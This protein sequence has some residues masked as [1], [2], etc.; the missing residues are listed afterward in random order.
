MNF[1][2]VEIF[3][4]IMECASITEAAVR[5]SLS[6]PAV[7]KS[8]KALEDE[9]A[10]RLFV[11][12]TKGLRATDEA[13]ELYAEASR[14]VMGFT[15]L[16]AFAQ[17]LRQLRHARI[18]V[19]AMTALCL[20]W[21]P[22]A[23]AGFVRLYPEVSLEFQSRSS[24]DTVRLV[25]Q[26]EVDIGI[27]QARSDDLSVR[28]RKI[29]DLATVCAVPA[30][31]ALAEKPVLDVHDMQGQ[32]VILLSAGDEC[33]RRFEATLGAQ[34]VSIRS[35]MEVALGAMLCAMVDAGCGIGIVDVET[36]RAQSWRN[37]VFRR[38]APA[39]RVPIYAMQ[40]IHKPQSLAE[41]RFIEHLVRCA[42]LPWSG[43]EA[44]G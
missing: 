13:R 1:R 4:A 11:R 17:N 32:P 35:T 26:G 23:T 12:T 21:L 25:G 10:L 5:L 30:G 37:T 15:H 27:S 7:S 6:Q 36:A 42:P 16:G 18:V 2:Q 3:S 19:S 22:E 31:H 14:V 44:P 39:I 29:F 9:L 24:P 33:R 28:R 20:K 8:L 41:R 43:G 38:L 34:G 40:N